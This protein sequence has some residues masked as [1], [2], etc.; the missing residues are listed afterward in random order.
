MQPVSPTEKPS[1]S[2]ATAG[3]TI[4]A[5]GRRRQE[6][7]RCFYRQDAARPQPRLDPT[8]ITRRAASGTAGKRPDSTGRWF[9]IKRT[10]AP[11]LSR[12]KGQTPSWLHLSRWKISLFRGANFGPRFLRPHRPDARLFATGRMNLPTRKIEEITEARRNKQDRGQ[13]RRHRP[14]VSPDRNSCVPPA[15][16]QWAGIL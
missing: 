7:S 13:R 4:C 12:R 8:A 3:Q 11:G 1:P 16:P 2:S 6:S 10:E 5:D 9:C 14:E 15:H